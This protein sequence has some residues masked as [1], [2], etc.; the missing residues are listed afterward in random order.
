MAKYSSVYVFF[1][2]EHTHAFFEEH[3]SRIWI[4]RK[5]GWQRWQ[6]SIHFYSKK[7]WLGYILK[8]ANCT[9]LLVVVSGCQNIVQ[10]IIVWQGVWT[11]DSSMG[12]GCL[13]FGAGA[14]WSVNAA[15]T[16]SHLSLNY[17]LCGCKFL[18]FWVYTPG[19]YCKEKVS[20]KL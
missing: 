14:E 4:S 5:L 11:D 19:F 10:I 17:K 6:T 16:N 9:S 1:I 2:S 7:E 13:L 8:T 12:G 15:R 3:G 20:Q 18:E